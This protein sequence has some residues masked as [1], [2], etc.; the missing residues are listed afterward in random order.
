VLVKES[1]MASSLVSIDS[2]WIER[3]RL[4]IS[5][6]KNKSVYQIQVKSTV[7]SLL[8]CM[9][10]TVYRNAPYSRAVCTI[11]QNCMHHTGD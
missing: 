4:L 9:H 10:Y 11:E 7:D 2:A 8:R 3:K 1:S 5:F 6:M